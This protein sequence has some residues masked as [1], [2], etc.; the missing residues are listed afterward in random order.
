MEEDDD[1]DDDDDLMPQIYSCES[2]S[3]THVSPCHLLTKHAKFIAVNAS[4]GRDIPCLMLRSV[5]KDKWNAL[6]M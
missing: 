2:Q 3:H 1:N 6:Y 4:I 5:E